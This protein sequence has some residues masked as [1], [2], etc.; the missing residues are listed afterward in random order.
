MKCVRALGKELM[1]AAPSEFS[2]GNLVRRVLYFIREEHLVHVKEARDKGRS[3]SKDL[4]LALRDSSSKTKNKRDRSGSTGSAG[5]REDASDGGYSTEGGGRG[6]GCSGKYSSFSPSPS[7]ESLLGNHAV[8]SQDD[9]SRHFPGLKSA[10]ISAINEMSTEIDNHVA[11]CQRAQDYIHNDECILTYGHAKLVELFLK[12]AAA[13][14]R[15]Q[16]II[17]EAAPGLDGHRLAANLSKVPNISITIIPDSNIYALMARINKVVLCP[18]AI[19]ADGGAISSS[20]HYMVALA[21]KD[22]SVPVVCVSPAFSLTPLFAHNQSSALQ[23][24]L[25]P[26]SVLAYDADVDFANVEVSNPAFDHIPPDLVSLYVTNDGSQLPSYV[27]RQ[28][29]EYYH[30]HDYVL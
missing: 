15:F 14:R 10:V 26:S 25:S 28:L 8:S 11:I 19:M 5:G 4:T 18:Q 9:F 6:S 1:T 20:G 21:A 24:L 23:Q 16:L 2:I 22:F 29:S 27:F 13:K 3:G 12:A 17:A 7:L 30:P